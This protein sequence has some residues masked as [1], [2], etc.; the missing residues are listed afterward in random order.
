MNNKDFNGFQRSLNHRLWG[1]SNNSTRHTNNW[2]SSLTYAFFV[3]TPCLITDIIPPPKI[4]MRPQGALRDIRDVSEMFQDCEPFVSKSLWNIYLDLSSMKQFFHML[5]YTVQYISSVS[6]HQTMSRW[7][8][9]LSMVQRVNA[10]ALSWRVRH[11][12][13]LRKQ[14]SA[15][16]G[17]V[18]PKSCWRPFST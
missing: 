7:W 18:S 6:G 13:G 4:V 2:K 16:Q 17:T 11:C 14:G 15:K 5:L 10:S 9:S 12:Q 3:C 8:W 1:D